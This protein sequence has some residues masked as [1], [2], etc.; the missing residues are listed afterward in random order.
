LPNTTTITSHTAA[1]GS[2]QCSFGPFTESATGVYSEIDSDDKTGGK[3]LPFSWTVT[4]SVAPVLSVTPTNAPVSAAAGSTN[5][6]VSNSGTG[7]LSYS[8]TV[9]SGSSWLTI[10]SGATGGNNG[11]INVSYS[12]NAGAQRSGTIQVTATGASG[13]PA[14]VTVTQA[15]VTTS[16]TRISE[17]PG[18]DLEFAPSESDMAAW[19]Q[20][21]PY[22]DI[23]VYV[24]G[25]NV[26]AVPESG[27]NGC[28]TNP[29]SSGTKQTNTNL[30]STWV[31]DVSSMGWAT[32][33][34]H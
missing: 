12:T 32:G 15:G 29:P 27:P 8:S 6:S 2:G 34:V 7:S 19:L 3:S 1:N 21:S 31:S 22:R 9:T 30:D 16:N 20:S 17:N 18:F 33:F 14:T 24:G 11:T 25:C 23:G 28:G 26:A 5:F 10:T 4:S 13:S